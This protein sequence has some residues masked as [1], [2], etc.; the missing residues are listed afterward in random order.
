MRALMSSGR[1]D[2]VISCPVT[3]APPAAAGAAAMLSTGAA[4]PSPAA[5]KAVVRTV[6]TLILSV[7]CT[8]ANALPA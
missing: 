6:S 2:L 5:S 4:P 3:V 7:D 8:V 1:S